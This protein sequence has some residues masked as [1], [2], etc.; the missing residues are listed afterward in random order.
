MSRPLT[1]ALTGDSILQRRLLSREDDSLR[2]L[3]D[4]AR[5]ADVAFTNRSVST[6]LDNRVEKLGSV[7]WA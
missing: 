2:P 1:L 3:F 6:T 5:G 7:E 4:M